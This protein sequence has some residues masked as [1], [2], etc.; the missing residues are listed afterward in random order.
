MIRK[1]LTVT[2]IEKDD[3]TEETHDVLRVTKGPRDTTVILE[4]VILGKFVVNTEDL[5]EAVKELEEF[6]NPVAEKNVSGESH[7]KTKP[8][9]D[10]CPEMLARNMDLEYCSDE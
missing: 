10:T 7:P 3:H 2:L 5:K 4:P 1:T 8:N 6:Y 9:L